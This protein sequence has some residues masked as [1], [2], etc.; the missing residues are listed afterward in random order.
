[1]VLG[2]D[3]VMGRLIERVS[4]ICRLGC[5]SFGHGH[6]HR[7]QLELDVMLETRV[8]MVSRREIFTVRCSIKY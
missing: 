2:I 8:S 5:G 1:M 4:G 6:G 7:C 3:C